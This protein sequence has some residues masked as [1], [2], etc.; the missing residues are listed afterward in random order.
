[1]T[2]FTATASGLLSYSANLSS[3]QLKILQ[4][5]TY[6]NET[7]LNPLIQLGQVL[8]SSKE[9]K[10]NLNNQ[11]TKITRKYLSLNGFY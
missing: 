11:H 6:I 3:P 8:M 5:V 10:V 1:M 2:T 7:K 9:V 4:L